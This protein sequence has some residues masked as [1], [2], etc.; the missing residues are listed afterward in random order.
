M[1]RYAP[2]HGEVRI[3]GIRR[4][5]VPVVSTLAAS[6]LDLLPIVSTTPLVPDFAYLVLLAW[7]LLRPEL[8]QARIA[9]PLGLF[10]DL[11]AGHPLGQSMALW[12]IT[13]LVFDLVDVRVGW[14]DYWMDWFFASLAILF[15]M[16]GGWYVA[17]MMGA[18]VEPVVLLPQYAL[19]VIAYPLVALCVVALDRWRLSR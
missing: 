12:T 14:R 16:A 6:L 18:R 4:Q 13:F 9:L 11:V 1:S 2:T 10:N 19:S 5:S 15:Y 3:F 17:R 8:W 7:R